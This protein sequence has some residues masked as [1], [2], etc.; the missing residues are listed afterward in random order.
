M[1]EDQEKVP[2]LAYVQ[3]V[4]EGIQLGRLGEHLDD[5]PPKL[6]RSEIDKLRQIAPKTITVGDA[7]WF[8]GKASVTRDLPGREP[9]RHI[10]SAEE[11]DPRIH[12][13]WPGEVGIT[14]TPVRH[15]WPLHAGQP[16]DVGPIDQY[17]SIR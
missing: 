1:H 4:A 6:G 17:I 2:V 13:D 3:N 10:R 14:P 9:C 8:A 15:R 11:F 12:R 16:G 7:F 5:R